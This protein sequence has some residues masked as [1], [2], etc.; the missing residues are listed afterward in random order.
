MVKEEIVEGLRQAISKKESLEQAMT[1]FY[2]AGYAKEEIEEAASFLQA[3]SWAQ[4]PAPQKP[5]QYPYQ[6]QSQQPIPQPT[7]QPQQ[8]APPPVQQPPAPQIPQPSVPPQQYYYPQ[9]P[10]VKPLTQGS[11]GVV[12]RVSGYGIKSKKSGRA[13]TIVLFLLLLLLLGILGA[14]IFYKDE[15]TAFFT[16]LFSRVLF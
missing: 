1:S 12:Q 6:Q 14:V 10:N 4:N 11:P 13:I 5:Q 8:Q 16:N 9:Q 7:P 2:N 3:P 15:L